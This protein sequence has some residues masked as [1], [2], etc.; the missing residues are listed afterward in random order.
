MIDLGKEPFIFQMRTT[1]EICDQLTKKLPSGTRVVFKEGKKPEIEIRNGIWRGARLSIHEDSQKIQLTGLNYNLFNF[2]RVIIISVAT[3]AILSIILSIAMSVYFGEIKWGLLTLGAFPMVLL[4][5]QAEDI[6]LWRINKTW[7][8][9]L[10][11]VLE[12]LK[13]R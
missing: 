7:S 6:V 10:G 8:V 5:M 11:Q 9:E 13:A 12:R 2:L 3:I 1:D 4:G